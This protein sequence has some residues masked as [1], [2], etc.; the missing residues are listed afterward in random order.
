MIRPVL[1]SLLF[2]ITLAFDLHAQVNSLPYSQGFSG[3]FTVGNDIEFIPNWYGNEVE[4]E[5]RIFQAERAG[6]PLLGIIPTSAFDADVQLRLDLSAFQLVSVSFKATA[7]KNGDGTRSA[8]LLMETSIDGGTTWI[9]RREVLRFANEDRAGFSNFKYDLPG[10]ANNRNSVLVRFFVTRSEA[11][12][13]TAPL[14][15]IDDVLVEEND[16]DLTAPEVVSVNILDAQRIRIQF[17]EALNATAENIANYTGVANLTSA[18]RSGNNQQV[19]LNF[20]PDLGIG[21]FQTLRIAGVQDLAGNSLEQPFF[22]DFV[23]NPT[24]PNLVFTEIMYNPPEAGTDSLEF[25][26]IYNRGTTPAQLG[27]LYF[28]D[29]INF[30]FPTA[31]LAPGAFYLIAVNARAARN[32]YGVEFVQWESGALNNAGETIMIKNSTGVTID[33]VTYSPSWGSNGDGT[34]LVLCDV[35]S[36]NTLGQNWSQ[37]NTPVGPRINNTQVFAHPGELCPTNASPTIRF[38]ETELTVLENVGS[39]SIEVAIINSNSTASSVRIAIDPS[40]TVLAGTDFNSS[41]S[42]P[43]TMNFEPNFSG[44]K[45][46]TLNIID[47][48]V[49]EPLKKLILRLDNAVNAV[50]G[51][52]NTYELTLIDNDQ[53]VPGIC[54]NE[55]MASNAT[56]QTD[57]FGEYDDWIEIYNPTAQPVD[58]ALYHITDNPNNLTKYQF[59][60][61]QPE[62]T[63]IPAN[64]FLIVWADNQSTQGALHTNFAL[65][66]SGEYVGLVMPNGTT[67]IDSVTFP[68]IASDVSYGRSNDCGSGWIVFGKP[69]LGASNLTS[70]VAEL[71]NGRKL[72]AYPNPVRSDLLYLSEPVNYELYDMMGRFLDAQ[73]NS[74]RVDVSTLS[75]GM[76][77]IRTSEGALLRFVVGK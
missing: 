5:R 35:N 45:S 19:T 18:I 33:S 70:S 20:N 24:T 3:N 14:L 6:N 55:L 10:A 22:Y 56:Y 41:V 26:E 43:F 61:G 17:S 40:S 74:N 7:A 49:A 30:S 39:V 76:Y 25:L 27:G 52:N 50:I 28:A 62:K 53:A 69:T 54:I 31:T 13:S 15:L 12:T 51:S 67:I 38:T 60:T 37:A 29:G 8:V 16:Q 73:I 63:T 72:I 1:L 71:S 68:G 77:I 64:G 57:E 11:G 47:D 9:S 42:F 66:A 46:I 65:S 59:P 48:A 58:L 21:I 44:T 23:Y 36:D 2:A 32:Q 34:S 4:T 75:N